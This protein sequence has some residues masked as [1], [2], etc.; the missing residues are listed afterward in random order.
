MADDLYAVLGV[1]KSADA[2]A[3]KKAYRKL[4]GKLHPDKNPGNKKAEETFK[5]VEPRLRRPRRRQEAQALRR[6]R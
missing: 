3:I 5:K 6:V 2:D 4:A 1:A